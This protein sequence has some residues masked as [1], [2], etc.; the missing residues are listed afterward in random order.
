MTS[1]TMTTDETATYDS[2]NQAAIDQLHRELDE[3]LTADGTDYAEITTA[4]GIVAWIF[5]AR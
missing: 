5:D 2:G 1:Y 4:D 3:R